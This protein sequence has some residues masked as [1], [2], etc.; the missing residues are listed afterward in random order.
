MATT[1]VIPSLIVDPTLV[2]QGPKLSAYA[3]DPTQIVLG[4]KLPAYTLSATRAGLILPSYSI[5]PLNFILST[6]GGVS[7]GGGAI[8]Y[9]DPYLPTGGVLVSGSAPYS[10]VQ[11]L[12]YTYST[13][14]GM[15]VGGSA[16]VSTYTPGGIAVGGSATVSTSTSYF[17]TSG[18]VSVGGGAVIAERIPTLGAGGVSVS[19]SADVV[20]LNTVTVVPAGGVQ[21]SGSAAVQVRPAVIGSGGA[22][23]TGSA[24]VAVKNP[25]F[26]VSGGVQLSGSAIAFMVPHGGVVTTENPYNAMLDAWAMNYE[27]NAISRYERLP[28]NSLCTIN[29]VTYVANAG[30]IY[31]LDADDD[32]GQQINASVGLGTTD[33][34][35]T[36]DKRVAYVHFE[37]R[38][39]AK[40]RLKITTNK[41]SAYFY[42]VLPSTDKNHGSL[43][44]PAKGLNGLY[45]GF[46]LDNTAGAD[47]ELSAI[48]FD[49]ATSKRSGR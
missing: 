29:G 23:V 32:A 49:V 10:A 41:K 14:G 27:T 19:G 18:G 22:V 12:L 34:G 5:S 28:A 42:D 17:A 20:A 9:N 40:M 3:L 13:I 30:G 4:P 45:W 37:M 35:D 44:E 11:V 25:V 1:A 46:R 16:A 43:L 33:F 31:A 38:S 21:L 47:F 39:K 48:T 26:N 7:V 36:H 24:A 15:S 6:T 8:I 2:V